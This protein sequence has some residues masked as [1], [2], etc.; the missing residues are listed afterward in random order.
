[1]DGPVVCHVLNQNYEL[2]RDDVIPADIRI[3]IHKQLLNKANQRRSYKSATIY[4]PNQDPVQTS[5]STDG[6]TIKFDLKKVGLWAIV[7]L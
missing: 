2:E 1:M 5:V 7:K 6:E 3:I 4:R